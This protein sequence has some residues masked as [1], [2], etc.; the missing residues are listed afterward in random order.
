MSTEPKRARVSGTT[1][2]C[3]S[4]DAADRLIA[5][6]PIVDGLEQAARGSSCA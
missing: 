3:N 6:K 2:S 5:P 4:T 1:R